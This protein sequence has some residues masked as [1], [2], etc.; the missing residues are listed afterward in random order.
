[1]E[2]VVHT[3]NDR[4]SCM[5]NRKRELEKEV[6]IL[7]IFSSQHTSH[8]MK[9]VCFLVILNS[10]KPTI[11]ETLPT[12]IGQ[13]R[14]SSGRNHLANHCIG[15]KLLSQAY[16]FYLLHKCFQHFLLYTTEFN[17]LNAFKIIPKCALLSPFE[18]LV[19]STTADFQPTFKYGLL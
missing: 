1:M 9:W 8:C 16:F 17:S 7:F 6:K 15:F 4:S 11:L 5:K 18:L 2:L 14:K 19:F 10:L 12:T 3:K 13:M